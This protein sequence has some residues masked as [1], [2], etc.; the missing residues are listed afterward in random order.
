MFPKLRMVEVFIGP[1]GLP[2]QVWKMINYQSRRSKL[3]ERTNN[4][5]DKL[6]RIPISKNS[7]ITWKINQK[8]FE[9]LSAATFYLLNAYWFPNNLLFY[10]PEQIREFYGTDSKEVER[11]KAKREAR[12]K[13]EEELFTRAP[14]SKQEKRLERHMLK[15]R[16]GYC[17]SSICIRC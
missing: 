3:S 9:K 6:E 2:Q 12:D 17:C 4:F 7:W 10:I 5:S 15:S 8:R 13:Q 16:N 11:Y 1:R 14:I